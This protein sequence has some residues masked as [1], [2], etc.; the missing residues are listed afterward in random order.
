[1]E[2]VIDCLLVHLFSCNFGNKEHPH[3]LSIT[4]EGHWATQP[5]KADMPTNVEPFVQQKV[6]VMNTS[7]MEAKTHEEWDTY[8]FKGHF[9]DNAARKV[10]IVRPPNSFFHVLVL[11]RSQAILRKCDLYGYFNLPPWGV[12]TRRAYE[13][14][15]TIEE[16]GV[17]TIINKAGEEVT[18]QILEEMISGALNLSHLDEAIPIPFQ[19]SEVDMKATF[20]SQ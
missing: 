8:I 6:W 4:E 14:M 11:P 12:D 15:T 2:D 17:Q 7:Y 1:M 9:Y 19:L 20:M 3:R 16:D 18:M 5:K 10:G 13:L